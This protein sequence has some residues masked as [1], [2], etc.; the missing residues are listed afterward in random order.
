MTARTPP[1]ASAIFTVQFRQQKQRAVKRR[2]WFP[3]VSGGGSLNFSVALQF[4]VER[5]QELRHVQLEQR[6]VIFH[7]AADIDRRGKRAEVS[8]FERADVVGADFRRVGDLL[9][10]EFFGFARR[11]ELFGNRW[12]SAYLA[13]LART[14]QLGNLSRGTGVSPV[15]FSQG[16]VCFQS[17]THGRESRATN[18]FVE[19]FLASRIPLV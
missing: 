2:C 13:Q 7:R 15:C 9:H 18:F 16:Q 14:W 4:G 3:S 5:G 19:P 17:T 6:R 11:A 10:R 12:H 8:L 1:A